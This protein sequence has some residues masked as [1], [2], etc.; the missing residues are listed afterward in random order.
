MEQCY[1]PLGLA[2][3]EVAWARSPSGTGCDSGGVWDAGCRRQ[4]AGSQVGAHPRVRESCMTNDAMNGSRKH[5]GRSYTAS[6]SYFSDAAAR[7]EIEKQGTL[8]EAGRTC[9][10]IV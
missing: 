7:L 4:M 8:T 10:W 9:G 1:T 3:A 2:V 6:E 5:A